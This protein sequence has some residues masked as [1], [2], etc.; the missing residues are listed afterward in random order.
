MKAVVLKG[1]I[2]DIWGPPSL[3]ASSDP[4]DFFAHHG[5]E[6]ALLPETL[7]YSLYQQFL[8]NFSLHGQYP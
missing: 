5:L 2:W 8:R 4:P 6:V 7:S 3:S 1:L